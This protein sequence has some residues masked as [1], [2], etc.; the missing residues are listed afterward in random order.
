MR[1]TESTN[2]F[3]RNKVYG[4][5]E[6][7]DQVYMK[8]HVFSKVCVCVYIYFTHY[9]NYIIHTYKALKSVFKDL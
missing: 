6:T 9:L 7:K 2:M 3:I 1:E 5:Y 8:T 4:E